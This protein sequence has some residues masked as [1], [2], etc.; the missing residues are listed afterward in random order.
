MV[1]GES[2]NFEGGVKWLRE[3]GIDVIDLNSRECIDMLKDYIARN[4]GVWNED[5]GEE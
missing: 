1:V 2:V 5:I 3:A 4:P